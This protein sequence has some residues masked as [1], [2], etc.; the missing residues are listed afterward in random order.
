MPVSKSH[1]LYN[2]ARKGGKKEADFVSGPT[3]VRGHDYL[4]DGIVVGSR[5]DCIS[6]GADCNA[7]DI[8]SVTLIMIQSNER[9]ANA[10]L[11]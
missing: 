5:H 3:S 8:I 4:P 2:D 9:V 10:F 6:I 1:T 11:G 7:C